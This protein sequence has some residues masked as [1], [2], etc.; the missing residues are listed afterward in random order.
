[1]RSAVLIIAG[2]SDVRT[3]LERWIASAGYSVR[4]LESEEGAREAVA[5]SDA[6]AAILRVE[7]I[8]LALLDLSRSLT[9]T[10]CRLVAMV[11]TVG[12]I[13]RFR[14][15]G[16]VADAYLVPPLKESDV[17]AALE[18]PVAQVKEDD[19]ARDTVGT[20]VLDG[21]RLNVR[22]HSLI[23]AA[24]REVELTG[25]EFAI[26][27]TLARRRGQVV[28][29]DRLLDAVSGRE[30]ESFDRSI[31]NLIARLRRKIEPD[32]KNPSVILTTRG[33]GYKLS[34]QRQKARAPRDAAPGRRSVAVAPFTNLDGG[35][36][37]SQFANSVSTLL[38]T[39]ARQIVGTQFHLHRGSDTDALEIGRQSGARYVVQGSVRRNAGDVRVDAR[40]SDAE[41]GLPVWADQFDGKVADMFALERDASA[42]IAR[43]IELELVNIEGSRASNC[44]DAADV[45]DLV[46]RGYGYLYRPRSMESLATARAFFERAL[47]QDDRQAE[48]L[49]GLAQTHISDTM[50]RWSADPPRQVGL[51]D[52]A[53]N[54]AIEISPRLACAYHVRGLV[55]RVRQQHERAIAAFDMAVQLNPSLAPAHAELGFSKQA[56][57][58]SF[59]GLTHSL[60]GLALAR[61]ISPRE[62]VLAN[63]LYGVGVGFLNCGEN[64]MAIRWLNEAIGLNP[65]LPTVAYLAAAYAL[66][67]D[68]ARATS[69]LM[70]FKRLRP[71][72][73]LQSFGRRTLADRQILPG[74]RVFEG[75]RKAGLRER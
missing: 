51:A 66:N 41:T 49:A 35:H 54:L 57:A 52:A 44:G 25:G 20:V 72:E 47:R 37:L 42:R 14:R 68:D 63:W 40:M 5:A 24:G 16:F 64:E 12:D 1:M 73:T 53:A 8:D 31:D 58:G 45:Q 9:E 26:L 30:A 19:V 10:G 71:R 38:L 69:A 3:T 46:V 60:D 21:M 61:R 7:R 50:C 75:L 22:G 2:D 11:G 6:T 27:A 15:F 28:S 65:L 23:D 48:A 43:A 32:P 67:G 55:S 59:E 70:E 4:R 62:P 56:L 39:E 74:S 33:A 17:L 18:S 13:R 29:R 36:E 34:T